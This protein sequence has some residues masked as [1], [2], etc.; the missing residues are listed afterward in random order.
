MELRPPTRAD[1]EAIAEVSIRF[2]LS[3]ETPQDIEAWFE[4]PS[5]ELERDARVALRDGTIVGYGDLGDRSGDGKVLWLDVRAEA[6]ALPSLLDFLE[7]RAAECAALGAKAKVWA[8]EQND[9][10]RGEI[11]SRGFRFDHYSRR[12]RIALD[13]VPEPQWPEGISVR[14]YDRATDEKPVYEAHQEA[15]SEER[16][17]ER[18]PYDEWVHWSY[19]EPFDPELWF[20]ATDGDEIAGIALCRTERG[21]DFSVGWVNIL[22]VRKPWRRRG[23]GTALLHHAFRELRTRGKT[24]AGLGV[25][26]N[27][28]QALAL[29]ERAGMEPE[30]SFVWYDKKL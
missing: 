12:M 20:V 7:A 23:L 19:R 21:G 4:M 25:D 17:F 11:E 14:T 2:G 9:E 3:D 30:R 28:E 10:A 26:G 1:A 6:E 29:Y 13:D 22:G 16:D 5:M 24:H 8:P 15:F 27:N 18:D